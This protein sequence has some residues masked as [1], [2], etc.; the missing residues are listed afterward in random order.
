METAPP[1]TSTTDTST[2]D[3]STIRADVSA[4]RPAMPVL[5]ALLCGAGGLLWLLVHVGVVPVLVAVQRLGLG[6][7]AVVVV[8]HLGLIVAMGWAWW[9]HG[10]DQASASGFVFARFVRDSAAEALPLAQVGGFVVGG[11]ALVLAGSGG[12]FAAASTLVDITI[13]AFAKLPYTLLGL[14]LL[15]VSGAGGQDVLWLVAALGLGLVLLP[16]IAFVL[17]QARAT[18]WIERLAAALVRRMGGAWPFDAGALSAEIALLYG[19]RAAVAGGFCIHAATWLLSGVELWLM[20][21]L[22]GSDL[23]LAPAIVIDSLLNGLRGFAF[24]IPGALGVQEAGYVALGALFAVPPEMAVAISL[25]RRG[26][27][28]SYGVPGVLLWQA[29]EGRRLRRQ[30]A[31]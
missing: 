16:P 25:L 7:F 27:D 30:P 21:H 11:R 13:E 17:V 3:A 8:F 22:M 5:I 23:G 14:A 1:D 2:T 19:R 31:E 18:R 4:R 26:R 12:L 28:L 10:P 24:A 29:I 15:A 6:G 9:L 20:L